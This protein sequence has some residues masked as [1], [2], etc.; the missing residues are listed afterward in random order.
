MIAQTA[1]GVGSIQVLT[2]D[3]KVVLS[4]ALEEF[5]DLIDEPMSGLSILFEDFDAD[6]QGI[7]SQGE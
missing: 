3:R 2:A 1:G 7:A 5:G 4:A 6:V